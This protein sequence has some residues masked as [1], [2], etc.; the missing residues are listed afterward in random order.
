MPGN[1]LINRHCSTLPTGCE[2]EI[3]RRE[4][5]LRRCGRRIGGRESRRRVVRRLELT[6]ALLGIAAS[7]GCGGDSSG[8][9][10]VRVGDVSIGR[11]TVAHWS[12][13][14]GREGAV[15]S[16]FTQLT[17]S[18]REKA[19]EFLIFADWLIDEAAGRGTPVSPGTIERRLR[20]KID[21]VPNGRTEFEQE[22]AATGRTVADVK[23]E[24]EAEAAATALR[25]AVLRGIPSVTRADVAEFY[26]RNH[27]QFRI[28][29]SRDVDLIESIPTRSA[30]IS[31]GKRI[32]AGK[33]FASR[34]L[35]ERVAKQTRNEAAHHDNHGLVDA[36]FA[37]QRGKVAAPVRFNHAWVLV[38]VRKIIPASVRPL[39]AVA[40]GIVAKLTSQRRRLA[41]SSFA[42][43]FRSKWTAKT[44]CRPGYIVQK[45]SQ[46]RGPMSP[47]SNPLSG[48]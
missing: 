7:V 40:E 39:A 14:L 11:S 28:E 17:G 19:L 4:R 42:R 8:P 25:A 15:G 9:T 38:V 22:A 31:L 44:D 5:H 21:A 12:R 33:R 16:S 45:C 34:A 48:P 13:A 18:N 37:A 32:G 23:L 30:A 35:H 36:I 24:I 20:E 27:A 26:Q 47:E 1:S 46:Y 6:A 41:L 2:T 43:A 3:G 29:D 10:V